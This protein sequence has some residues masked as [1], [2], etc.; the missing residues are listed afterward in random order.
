MPDVGLALGAV[1]VGT[2]LFSS[3]SQGDAAEE[4][5]QA[6]SNAEAAATAARK[7]MFDIS[8]SLQKPF[9][10]M[11]VPAVEGMQEIIN[12]STGNPEFEALM[13]AARSGVTGNTTATGGVRGGNDGAF[14]DLYSPTLM[15]QLT[16]QRFTRLAGIGGL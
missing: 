7:K 3:D 16:D 5:Q 12:G 4:A 2:S 6:Q 8:S 1:S 9:A 14:A 11:G 15:K 10:D 13:S